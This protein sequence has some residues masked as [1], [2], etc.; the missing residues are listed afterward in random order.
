L[1][2]GIETE[3][4]DVGPFLEQSGQ[5]QHKLVRLLGSQFEAR[6]NATRA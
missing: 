6:E 2:Y 4:I 5:G 3:E 1:G